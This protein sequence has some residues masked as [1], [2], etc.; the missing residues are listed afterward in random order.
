MFE[1]GSPL[2]TIFI[3]TPK[4]ALIFGGLLYYSHE[5]FDHET[6]SHLTK[7]VEDSVKA[8]QL[9]GDNATSED[10]QKMWALR[11]TV[12]DFDSKNLFGSIYAGL[13]LYTVGRPLMKLFIDKEK[14]EDKVPW[15]LENWVFAKNIFSGLALL[16]I[17]VLNFMEFNEIQLLVTNIHDAVNRHYPPVPELPEAAINPNSLEPDPNGE[18]FPTN[19][20]PNKGAPTSGGPPSNDPRP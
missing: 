18:P 15:W 12:N 11:D 3:M 16:T 17:G 7:Q 1:I 5:N 8:Y 9:L 2:R 13:G 14:D 10:T 19:P 4:A 6:F 20:V